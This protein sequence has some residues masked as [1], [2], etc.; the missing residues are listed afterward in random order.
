MKATKKTAILFLILVTSFAY[1]QEKLDSE[2]ALEITAEIP[3]K[4]EDEFGRLI[5]E[6]V[7]RTIKTENIVINVI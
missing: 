1:A 6:K 5:M 4:I 3:S 7:N 2:L